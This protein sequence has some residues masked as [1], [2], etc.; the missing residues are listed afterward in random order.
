MKQLKIILATI[1]VGLGFLSFMN[2]TQVPAIG[3]EIGDKAPFIHTTLI[4]GEPFELDSLQG[5]MVI[6]NFWASYDAPSRMNNFQLN[7]IH[8]SYQD[9]R[10]HKGQDLEVVSISLD[11]FHYPLQLAIQQDETAHFRHVC[12]FLGID[13]PI[14]RAFEVDA[15]VNLLIDGHGRILAKDTSLE[16]IEKS[17]AFL[18]RY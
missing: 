4:Q 8:S 13:G 17:L 16:K 14:A 7:Q 9:T 1:F 2:E 18:A 3:L 10:F 5:K 11:R 15:P 6:L 12:D